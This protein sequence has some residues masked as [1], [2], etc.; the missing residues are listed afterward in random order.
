MES[1]NEQYVPIETC[2]IYL[3]SRMEKDES[4]F[5]LDLFRHL[6]IPEV[7]VVSPQNDGIY[8]LTTKKT[9]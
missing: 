7:G 1:A 6:N 3:C 4:K 8:E 5:Y 2:A 9:K